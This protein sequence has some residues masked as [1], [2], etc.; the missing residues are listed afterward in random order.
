MKKFLLNLLLL[1]AMVLPFATQ[2]QMTLT[3]HNGT[4]TNSYVPVYGLY[5]DAFLKCQSVYPAAELGVMTGGQITGLTYYL[6]SMAT[7]T[8]DMTSFKVYL[9]EVAGTTLSSYASLTNAT[10]VY[11]GTLSGT[12]STMAITFTTPYIYQGGNLLIAV[13]NIAEGDYSS[14]SFYGETVTGASIQGYDYDDI[15]DAPAGV[16]NFLPK[17]TFN[18]VPGQQSCPMV[19]GLTVSNITDESADIS[20]TPGGTESQWEIRVSPAVD[21]DTLISVSSTSYSFSNM[22]SNTQYTVTVKAICSSTDQSYAVGTTFK[23]LCGLMTQLP[24]TETFEN[25]NTT[26]SSSSNFIDCWH[27]LNNGTSYPGYPYVANSSSYNH[28]PNGSKGLYWYGSTTTGSYGDYQIVV[29][30]AIDTDTYTMNTLQLKFWAKSSSASYFPVFYTGVMTDPT[31]PTTFQ[32]IDTIAI[33]NTTQWTEFASDFDNFSGY[34]MYAAIKAVRPAATWYAYVDD[35]TLR[36]T[37][38]CPEVNSITVTSTGY[39]SASISWTTL[40][41]ANISSYEIELSEADAQS[42]PQSFTTND[43]SY[44]FT[45][46]STGTEYLVKVRTNCSSVDGEWDS[47]TFTTMALPCAELDPTTADTTTIGTGT[48]GI[49]GCLAYSSW[50]NTATQQIWT[51]T[52][53]AA[54]GM[55]SGAITGIDLG[56]TACTSYNK[57]I[58]IFIGNS[59]VTSISSATLVSPT[60]HQQVYGPVVIPSGTSGYQH[61]EFDSPFQWDGSSSIMLTVLVNQSGSSQTSS[62]GMTGYY[63]SASN[64]AAY[65]YQD[66]NPFTAANINAGNAGST[67]SYRPNIN[68]YMGDCLAYATCV[69]PNAQVDSVDQTSASISWAPGYQETSWTVDYR[70]DGESTWTTAETSTSNTN[71]TISGLSPNTVYQ[72]RVGSACSDTTV[73]ATVSFRTACGAITL[74]PYVE[75]FESQST[76]S[77]SSHNFAVCWHHLNNGSSYFGYPYISASTTYN[78]TPNGTKGL[79]WYNT[80]TTGT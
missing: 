21:G 1:A 68:F 37:P 61:Y 36:E 32:V 24:F 19:S 54:A 13:Y 72:V 29:L 66:S 6:S 47:T 67:F 38:A 41:T 50:G 39:A 26:S 4:A 74:L 69:A 58:T 64:K 55:T 70:A 76:G 71:T 53:L 78:H 23:T 34:G 62:S 9:M 18:Y 33:G 16:Q 73:Y 25:Q 17:T 60:S 27:L 30:P 59:N 11:Q 15:D 51:A 31:D 42:T 3:V 45:G 40:G 43:M 46:L 10:M 49:S 63:T 80:T 48:T 77:T 20:W 75:D 65:R 44:M 56:F 8:W 12:S 14:C 28:T 5:T 52:E 35:I 2:A 22:N 7:D 79:Y 57:E